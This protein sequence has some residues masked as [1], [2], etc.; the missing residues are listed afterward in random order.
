MK[1]AVILSAMLALHV[2]TGLA[3]SKGNRN[4]EAAIRS[5][6][7]KRESVV[8]LTL[9]AAQSSTMADDVGAMVRAAH[10]TCLMPWCAPVP[11]I[12]LVVRHGK[13]V[14]PRLM[15]LLPDDPDDPDLFYF[16]WDEAAI[17]AG[18][19]FDWNVEQQAAVALCRIY[20]VPLTSCP[21]YSNRAT[22]EHNRRIKPFFAKTIAEN[23]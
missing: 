21:M 19:Q 4:D 14:V 9:V 12:D 10:E 3:Q 18:K 7:T 11:K 23:P 20:G 6:L 15:V 17:L 1:T 16:G 5:V 22:R 2:A 13:A 8:S